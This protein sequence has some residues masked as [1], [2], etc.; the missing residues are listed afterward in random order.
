MDAVATVTVLLYPDGALSTLHQETTMPELL[1]TSPILPSLATSSDAVVT[2]PSSSSLSPPASPSQGLETRSSP[3]AVDSPTFPGSLIRPSSTQASLT[4]HQTPLYTGLAFAI[5]AGIAILSTMVFCI[6]R[7]RESK[8]R[9]SS[10][11]PWSRGDIEDGEVADWRAEYET[12]QK[13]FG[14]PHHIPSTQLWHLPSACESS[15][16][17]HIGAGGGLSGAPTLHRTPNPYLTTDATGFPYQNEGR[18]HTSYRKPTR[19]QLPSHLMNKELAA[20]YID[21]TDRMALEPSIGTPRGEVDA[22]RYLNLERRRES[23]EAPWKAASER[24]RSLVERF[25]RTNKTEA[26]KH[27][28]FSTNGHKV[29]N[30]EFQDGSQEV[31]TRTL[32]TNLINAFNAVAANIPTFG[33]YDEGD[34]LSPFPTTRN[35]PMRASTARSRE[36]DIQPDND[37]PSVTSELSWTLEDTGNGSGVVHLHP[38]SATDGPHKRRLR[39]RLLSLS[40]GNFVTGQVRRSLSSE[41]RSVTARTSHLTLAS[42]ARPRSRLDLDQRHPD[43]E[44]QASVYSNSSLIESYGSRIEPLWKKRE[45]EDGNSASLDLSLPSVTRRSSS[46]NSLTPTVANQVT[47]LLRAR[48]TFSQKLGVSR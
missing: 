13:R 5:I 34:P 39:S 3:A 10:P 36:M 30:H 1:P 21:S 9:R 32:T 24:P 16:V 26:L 19:R 8:R 33:A 25:E 23:T 28:A 40:T 35:R 44:S 45:E 37:P 11:L 12:A 22:P 38:S 43:R 31:W 47:E 14:P 42:Y 4:A 2:T 41:S 15:E 27:Q 48:R 7:V 29:P 6:I 18:L 17:K 20:G 46:W